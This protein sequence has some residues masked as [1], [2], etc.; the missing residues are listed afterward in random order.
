MSTANSWHALQVGIQIQ[1]EA[2]WECRTSMRGQ[3]CMRYEQP[4]RVREGRGS[5]MYSAMRMATTSA[6]S[7]RRASLYSLWQS[8][9][10]CM[11]SRRC[12][13]AATPASNPALPTDDLP[14]AK[15][16]FYECLLR[17]EIRPCS[18][19]GSSVQEP[20]SIGWYMMLPAR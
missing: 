14:H 19:H 15:R 11:Y 18:L 17:P 12:A 10:S 13:R 9:S 7:A 8:D 6:T 5:R 2:K 1:S 16:L 4:L 3:T 20:M